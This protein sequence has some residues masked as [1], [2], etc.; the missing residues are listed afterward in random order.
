MIGEEVGE[1]E[2][3][4][5]G[6]DGSLRLHVRFTRASSPCNDLAADLDVEGPS[7]PARN[8]RIGSAGEEHIHLYSLMLCKSFRGLSTPGDLMFD[9]PR[10]TP[11][12]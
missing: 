10:T 11:V 12:C 5:L 7:W 6:M 2:R 9:R 4:C 1:E 8:L 3:R